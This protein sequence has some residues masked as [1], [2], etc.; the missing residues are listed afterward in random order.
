MC[1]ANRASQQNPQRANIGAATVSGVNMPCA[2]KFHATCAVNVAKQ[3]HIHDRCC[4]DIDP[5]WLCGRA[6]KVALHH[7]IR[8]KLTVLRTAGG[9]FRGNV[10]KGL[11]SPLLLLLLLL[12]HLLVYY[13]YQTAA[14]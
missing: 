13:S 4:T 12:L 11:F 5:L 9:M 1:R 10:N 2:A 14:V 3:H 7:G 6:C 8:I